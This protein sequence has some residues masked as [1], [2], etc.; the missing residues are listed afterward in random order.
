M[1][2]R[3]RT[4]KKPKTQFYVIL[5]S[6]DWAAGDGSIAP[7][8]LLT[9][10]ERENIEEDGD[11]PTTIQ[12]IPISRMIKELQSAGLW[13]DLVNEY[14]QPTALSPKALKEFIKISRVRTA[15]KELIE[16]GHIVVR[17]GMCYLPGEE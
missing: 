6:G 13:K 1:S 7:A 4:V 8:D 5:D 10:E 11:L 12:T 9:E 15:L 17:N 2:T 14:I 16:D 3:G